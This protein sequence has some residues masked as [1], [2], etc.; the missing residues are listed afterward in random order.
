MWTCKRNLLHDQIKTYEEA[1][2]AL[3]RHLRGGADKSLAR[4]TS[5]C[6]R[7][8]SIASLERVVCSYAELRVFSSYR[9]WNEAMP[10]DARDFNNMESCHQVFLSPPTRQGAEGNSRHSDRNIRGNMH[11][12]MPPSNTGWPSLNV[13][14]FPPVMRLV[15]D[16]AKQWPSR[17]LLIKFTS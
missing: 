6:R 15:L 3:L 16:D 4:T 8:E 9:G 1:V 12:R 2:T 17:R 7:T 13:V 11:R 5:R 14:I 10:G